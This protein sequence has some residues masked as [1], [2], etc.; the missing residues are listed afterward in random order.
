MKKTIDTETGTYIF[1][2]TDNGMVFIIDPEQFADGTVMKKTFLDAVEFYNI[3]VS[4]GGIEGE[5]DAPYV[6]NE[7]EFL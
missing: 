6:Q 7:W 3:L 1:A 4:E 5:E 2:E